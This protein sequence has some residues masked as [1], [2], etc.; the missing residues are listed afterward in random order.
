MDNLKALLAK[1]WKNETLDEL[2]PGTYSVDEVMMVRVSGTVEKRRDQFVASTVSIPLVSTLAL[3]LEKS[4]V[5]RQHVVRIIREA[6]LEAINNGKNKDEQIE[7]RMNDVQQAI[8]V[9]RNEL[10]SAL[11]RQKRSGA[12]DTKH[13]YIEVLPVENDAL[14]PAAA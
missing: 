7:S 10:I 12:L 5:C 14:A 13:L 3:V 9:V 4:G 1:A 8:E 2:A 6:I 11:P